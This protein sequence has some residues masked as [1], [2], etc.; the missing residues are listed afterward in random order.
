M[1]DYISKP[2]D[3]QRLQEVLDKWRERHTECTII[4]RERLEKSNS[5]LRSFKAS[6]RK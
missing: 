4:S 5:P 1:D 6:S 2:V 3:Q